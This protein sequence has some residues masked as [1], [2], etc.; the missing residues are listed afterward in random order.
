MPSPA[1]P[2]VISAATKVTVF[3]DLESPPAPTVGVTETYYDQASSY[4]ALVMNLKAYLAARMEVATGAFTF[5]YA[6]FSYASK[7]RMVD[8]IDWTVKGMQFGG[9]WSFIPT[10]TAKKPSTSRT[11]TADAA[12]LLRLKLS[13]GPSSR[14]FLHGFP[15]QVN[16][17][18][19]YTP[20]ALSGWDTSIQAL[21]NF[22]T[23]GSNIYHR[24]VL[25]QPTTGENYTGIVNAIVPKLPR[26]FTVTPATGLTPTVGQLVSFSNYGA[27][28]VGLRGQKRI[29]NVANAPTTFDVGGAAPIGSLPSPSSATFLLYNVMFATGTYGEVERI[30]ERHV[31]RPFGQYPGKKQSTLSLRR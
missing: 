20:A 16:D 28:I 17:A 11:A 6:R 1:S 2:A 7:P 26:G 24:Y 22:L 19:Q 10:T 12:L 4:D 27:G 23:V 21:I 31:G 8:F 25:P 18:N 9:S 13:T 15:S 29:T 3:Y 5:S 30:T 14:V